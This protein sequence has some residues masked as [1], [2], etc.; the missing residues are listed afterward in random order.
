MMSYR[1][2]KYTWAKPFNS[3][4]HQWEL[5]GR[6]GGLHFHA[7]IT[8]GY[9]VTAGLEVHYLTPPDY[10][11]NDPPSQL[12]CWL[13]K[14]PCWHDGTSLYASETLWPMVEPMLRS[15]DHDT[16][17]RILERE[18]DERFGVNRFKA[19]EVNV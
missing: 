14:C 6:H 13:L 17:F 19:E 4:R 16:I 12:P 18:A 15:G 7:S 10:M 3:V 1:H 2:H 11:R 5:V 9:G 8:D